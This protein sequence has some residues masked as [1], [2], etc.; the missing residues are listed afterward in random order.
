LLKSILTHSIVFTILFF[1]VKHLHLYG[2]T[3]TLP[4]DL[5]SMYL[6]HYVFSLGICILFSY[7]AYSKILENQ[8]GFIYLGALFLKI[9]FFV[10]LHKDTVLST[11]PIPR[12]E[13]V[14]M[15]VPLA[16]FLLVE[17]LFIS[18]ILRRLW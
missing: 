18:K 17:V 10:V 12:I 15:L 6:F 2:I 5:G 16:L 11:S 13:R 4:F 1:V 9:I 14:H 3:D 8:L 7:L